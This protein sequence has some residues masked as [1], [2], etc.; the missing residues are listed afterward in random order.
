[1]A[2]YPFLGR[3]EGVIRYHHENCDG[4]GYFGLSGDDLPGISRLI[5]LADSVELGFKL[6]NADYAEKARIREYVKGSAGKLFAPETAAAFLEAS[7]RARA[8]GSISG[9]STWAPPSTS[10]P[11][12]TARR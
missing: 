2:G 6:W 7:P 9:K 4:S 10:T 11:P 1:V 8:S 12:P 5:R 3:L